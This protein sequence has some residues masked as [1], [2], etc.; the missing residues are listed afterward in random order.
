MKIQEIL[1]NHDFANVI[2]FRVVYPDS[3]KYIR[4]TGMGTS[5]QNGKLIT[6]TEIPGD[7]LA[8][9]LQFNMLEVHEE[10]TKFWYVFQTPDSPK[11]VVHPS[12]ITEEH[13]DQLATL[14]DYDVLSKT[15][16]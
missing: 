11:P 3:I 9:L 13:A 15:P 8:N 1:N 6:P 14:G 4:F 16:A 5:L 10:E 2:R 12:P 7:V